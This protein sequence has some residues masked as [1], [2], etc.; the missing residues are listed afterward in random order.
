LISRRKERYLEFGQYKDRI[1]KTKEEVWLIGERPDTAQDTGFHFFKYCRE[2][3]PEKRIYYVIK[4]DSKDM[5]NVKRLGNVIAYGSMK[6]FK[7]TAL[8]T[9]FIGSHDLEYILPTRES[10]WPSYQEGQRVF[11]QH[12]VLGRKKVHYY[13]ENYKYPFTTFCV[14]SQKEF[15]LVT[16]EMGYKPEEVRITGLS[17]F[18]ELLSN[19]EIDNTIIVMPTWRDWIK[20]ERDFIDSNYFHNYNELLKDKKLN[21][22]LEENN[23]KLKF[24]IHYRMQHYT[25]HYDKI[26]NEDIEMVQLGETDVQELLKTSKLLITDY[27]SVSFDFNYMGKPVIFYHFDFDSFFNKGLLRPEEETFI[28]DISTNK[29]QLVTLIEDY[30]NNEFKEKE[31]FKQKHHMNFTNIDRKNCERIFDVVVNQ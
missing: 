5:E 25:S 23:V 21:H 19:T 9:V 4:K 24:Y 14:S 12:G 15:E 18:D 3:Y 31:E 2:N 27:S 22:L 1:K 6:H 10:D 26:E 16:K 7:I 30:I 11:L 13:K 28:G 20:N 17:R 8:A 29:D